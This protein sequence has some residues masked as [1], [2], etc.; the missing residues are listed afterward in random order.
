[1]IT[2]APARIGSPLFTTFINTSL[3]SVS[4]NVADT[5]RFSLASHSATTNPERFYPNEIGLY[6]VRAS[7][8]TDSITSYA[9][10]LG[11]R[12]TD[13]A[14]VTT[15]V[16]TVQTHDNYSM[17]V[18]ADVPVTDITT[19]FVVWAQVAP[20]YG[21]APIQFSCRRVA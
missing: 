17:S 4:F 15:N 21:N 11:I 19:Y 6:E 8:F 2:S 12:K 14:A 7:M 13:G 5:Y 1:M 9:T 10:L 16:A 3:A 20:N 18:T